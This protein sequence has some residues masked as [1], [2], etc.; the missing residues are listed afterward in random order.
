MTKVMIVE[1]NLTL[2]ES[3]AFELEMRGYEVIQA[4]D[5]EA[6]LGVLAL[7]EEPPD[8]IVS[9]IA[10]PRMDGYKLLETVRQQDR[11]NRVCFLFL[12]AF[13]SPN[14]VHLGK[15]L[16]VDDYLV[17]P[18]KPDDLVVAMENKLKRVAQFRLAAQRETD[19]IRRK[20]MHV[21]THEL[22]TPLTA[23]FGGTE[24]LAA[25]LESVPDKSIQSMLT[26]VRNGTARL[27]RLVSNILYLIAIDSGQLERQLAQ[28]A[29][30]VEVREAVM[31]AC[32]VVWSDPAFATSSVQLELRMPDEALA[33]RGL[34]EYV[35][36]MVTEVL[37]NAFVFS[38]SYG[39]VV[40]EVQ[41]VDDDVLITITDEGCGIAREQQD[42]VWE[43]YVQ[44]D[45]DQFEQQGLGLGLALVRESARLHGGDCTIN[46][47]HTPG[48]QVILRLPA[49]IYEE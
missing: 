40:I 36:M 31:T 43:R 42:L 12:T 15:E 27:S 6:A 5:G 33:V 20:F 38:P 2:L 16:G 45:R 4:S 46:S 29:G 32:N 13:N 11:W 34:W 28:F 47:Q 48:T 44:L 18:F 39:K 10:M 30:R 37:R 35:V 23:I 25:S 21:V 26:I 3:I 14:A 7:M 19:E 49:H 1:D 24:V 22:R 41:C 17:K 8:I 9:D